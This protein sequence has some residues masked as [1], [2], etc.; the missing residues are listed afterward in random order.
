MKNDYR[1]TWIVSLFDLMVCAD[2]IESESEFLA[3]MDLHKSMYANHCTFNDELD[4]LNGFLNEDLAHKIVQGNP[5]CLSV[6]RKKLI[7]STIKVLYY[8]RQI[9]KWNKLISEYGRQY[10]NIIQNSCRDK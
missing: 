7:R 4:V 1:D 5:L 3:Y 9:T 10:N 2:F 6:V 8:H